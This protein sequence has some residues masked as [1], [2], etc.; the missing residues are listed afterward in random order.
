L[1][2]RDIEI[3]ERTETIQQL[4]NEIE[5]VKSQ[6]KDDDVVVVPLKKKIGELEERE[7]ELEKKLQSNEIEINERT[8][9]I[10]Q[11]KNDIENLKSQSRDDLVP[12]KKKIGELEEREQELLK[13]M[14]TQETE[15]DE[16]SKAVQQLKVE[17]ENLKSIP[18]ESTEKKK[19][20]SKSS[21]KT[22]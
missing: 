11:L 10:K 6:P 5:N 19:R 17:I 18:K 15:M 3:N 13:K 1:K 2:T 9:T 8:E 7:Q 12:L 20:T 22:N 16:R 14:Q 21:T 4:K